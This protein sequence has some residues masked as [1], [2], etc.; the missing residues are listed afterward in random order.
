MARATDGEAFAV[1]TSN[2]RLA[3]PVQLD[4]RLVEADRVGT[5]DLNAAVANAVD[6]IVFD[7]AGN[8]VEY[9][10]L[11]DHPGEVSFRRPLAFDRVPASAMLHWFR[12]DRPGQAR[13]VPDITPA[14]PLF[15][16]LRRF[17]LAVIA[18]AETAADF[19]GILYTDAPA[20]GEADAAEPFEPI[21][22]EKRALVTMPGGWKMSQLQ[23]E[24]PARTMSTCLPLGHIPTP[25]RNPPTH[26]SFGARTGKVFSRGTHAATAENANSSTDVRAVPVAHQYGGLSESADFPVPRTTRLRT[27]YVTVGHCT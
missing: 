20:S 8:P 24:H 15:A 23:A 13:G 5:P 12:C 10:V 14:L 9:H 25:P 27:A 1:L 18:A 4:L 22:L 2:P 3:T 19:A 6:G 16:Q 21:E 11:R 17:T 26:A 7:A